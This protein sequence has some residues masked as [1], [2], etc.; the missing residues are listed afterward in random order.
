MDDLSK[1]LNLISLGILQHQT[2]GRLRSLWV[3]ISVL[4][5]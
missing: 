2:L 3:K 4:N 5:A 1:F